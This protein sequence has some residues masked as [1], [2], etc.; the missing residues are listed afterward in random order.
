[1][2]LTTFERAVVAFQGAARYRQKAADAL[3]F[4]RDVQAL[5]RGRFAVE[6]GNVA[7][8]VAIRRHQ[9]LMRRADA[10]AQVARRL[11]HQI[12]F[13]VCHRRI[14]DTVELPGEFGPGRR[15]A[16]G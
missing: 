10:A 8:Q 15:D 13:P 2:S 9:W 3:A 11:S 5:G 16:A 1:M 4:R 12:L 7:G 6:V 14:R